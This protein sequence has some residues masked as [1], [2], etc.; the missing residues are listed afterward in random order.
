MPFD[1]S[2]SLEVF[3]AG[4]SRSS[5]S[6]PL[7][8]VHGAFCGGWVWTEHL[9]PWFAERGRDCRAPSLRGHGGS[10]GRETLRTAS[11]SDYVD[12][13]A[14]VVA[15]LDRPPVVIGHS[16]GGMV[17]QR[18]LE[19]F[20]PAAFAAKPPVAGA[21]LV[22]SV[23][24]GGLWGTTWHMALNDPLLFLQVGAIQTFG[25]SMATAEGLHRAMFSAGASPGLTKRYMERMQEESQQVQLDMTMTPPPVATNG[26]AIPLAVFGAAQ[27]PFVPPWM[28]HATARHY[29]VTATII[30]GIGH[31]MMLDP[32]WK[33]FATALE[34]WLEEKAL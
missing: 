14:N 7:V 3:R 16:M 12:D 2:I 13:L 20:P 26:R 6:T 15:T 8:L 23:P 5:H 32:A 9:M 31:A 34:R 30:D 25:T 18:Y 4:P 28:A 19:R 24:P 11:L 22:A 21:V 33:K 1:S 29:G 10:G 17:V 27:D